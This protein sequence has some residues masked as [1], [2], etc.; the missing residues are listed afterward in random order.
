MGLGEVG[1]GAGGGVSAIGHGG[2]EIQ[3]TFY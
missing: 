1:V 3:K 2:K